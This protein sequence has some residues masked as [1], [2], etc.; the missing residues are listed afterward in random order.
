MSIIYVVEAIG[1]GVVKVGMTRDDAYV[2][3]GSLQ[4]GSP[5]KLRLAHEFVLDETIDLRRFEKYAHGLLHEHWIHGE[6]FK[7][8][9]ETAIA[10][11]ERAWQNRPERPKDPISR[12]ESFPVVMSAK[13]LRKKK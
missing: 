1:I 5:V 6:W 4:V 8:S 13:R 3:M 12:A 7:C 11:I 10:A 2:R 9:V